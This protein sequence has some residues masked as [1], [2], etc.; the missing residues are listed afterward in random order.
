MKLKT[1]D[2]VEILVNPQHV[3]SA[4]LD[5]DGGSATLLLHGFESIWGQYTND[6]YTVELRHSITRAS[7]DELVQ[8]FDRL[9]SIS[10]NS[11]QVA[12][13]NQMPH[14]PWSV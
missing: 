6:A 3:I 9:E 11:L 8:Y 12:G 13:G 1:T 10:T 7:Y 2:G 14:D 4:T 5:D